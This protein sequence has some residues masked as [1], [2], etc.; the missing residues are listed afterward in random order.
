MLF[1]SLLYDRIVED[2]MLPFAVGPIPAEGEA[3]A[4]DSV[5]K[6]Y[7]KR[8]SEAIY[9]DLVRKKI[10]VDKRRPD[11]RTLGLRLRTPRQR[12]C[13]DQRA[14]GRSHL[15]HTSHRPV[16]RGNRIRNVVPRPGVEATSMSPS[17]NW[18]IR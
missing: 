3:P 7:L 10:A 18:T 5:T 2:A 14:G 9:K 1:R 17:C 6:Q 13:D 11:G 16:T 12:R 4:K 8:A 15:P